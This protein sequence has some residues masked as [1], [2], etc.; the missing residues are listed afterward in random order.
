M[1]HAV[2]CLPL[3]VA[4]A[5]AGEVE[6]P[7]V[8]TQF[9][10]QRLDFTLGGHRALVIQPTKAAAAGSKPWLWY[11]PTFIGSLPDPSHGWMF[12]QLLAKGFA[13]CGVEVG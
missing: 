2:W 9:G 13:V 5:L 12:E 6:A 11:A 3:L 7:K 10:A 1:K 4:A 8:S